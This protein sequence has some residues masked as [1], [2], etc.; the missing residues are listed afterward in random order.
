MSGSLARQFGPWQG[1]ACPV[2]WRL[3]LSVANKTG[4]QSTPTTLLQRLDEI[5][6]FPK[7][8]QEFQEYIFFPFVIL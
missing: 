8:N 7:Y 1:I 5:M 3:L 2:Q 4:S 6:F